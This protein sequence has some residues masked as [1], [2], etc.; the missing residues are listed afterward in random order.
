MIIHQNRRQRLPASR[1]FNFT[2]IEFS[3]GVNALA[4]LFRL[5]FL[6]PIVTV[7]QISPTVSLSR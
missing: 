7:C 4:W 3:Q 1:R 5:S 6:H 2:H